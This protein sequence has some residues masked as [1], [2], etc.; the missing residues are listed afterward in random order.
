MKLTKH[1]KNIKKKGVSRILFIAFAA[2][3]IV[4][5]IIFAFQ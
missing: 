4:L 5:T 3:I 1:L 2:M